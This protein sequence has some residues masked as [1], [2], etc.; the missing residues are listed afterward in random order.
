MRV[1][2]LASSIVLSSLVLV[3]AAQSQDPLPIIAFGDSITAGLREPGVDCDRP[4][5]FRGYTVHLENFLAADGFDV[6]IFRSG[7]CGETT[8]GGVTRIDQV[9]AT[10]P[11]EV[12]IIMEGTNDISRGGSNLIGLECIQENLE[13][14]A[15]KVAAA[16]R[17]PV[18][19][20]VIPYGPG[21]GPSRNNRRAR[22]LAALTRAEAARRGT[23][24]ADPFN[25]LIN[26]PNLFSRYFAAD[27][28]HLNAA[29]NEIMARAF[30]EPVSQAIENLCEPGVCE[31][32]DT[33][34]CLRD[35]RFEVSVDWQV[36]DT[37]GVGTVEALPGDETGNVWFFSPENIELVIKVLDGR[38]NTD[39]P[40]FWVFYGGLSE[41]RYRIRVVDRETCRQK[42]YF[43]PRGNFASIGDTAAFPEA[44]STP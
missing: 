13:I 33:T 14:M 3:S 6:G 16:G 43:N 29:G 38:C 20:S 35:G 28:F 32:S 1:F 11:G 26:M 5:T 22:N 23:P 2:P 18:F 30:V 42:V 40:A 12:V 27:G 19:S 37:M 39:S 25:F 24:F 15:D 9:L 8:F 17:S 4:S 36:D 7:V 31:P 44:C 10:R 34:L 21:A 41:V